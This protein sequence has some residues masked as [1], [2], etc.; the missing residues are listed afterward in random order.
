MA[1]RHV[2][3]LAISLLAAVAIGAYLRLQPRLRPNAQPKIQQLRVGM[4]VEEVEQVL[5]KAVW[6]R[7][8]PASATA[9]RE[10]REYKGDGAAKIFIRFDGGVA[11]SIEESKPR[12]RLPVG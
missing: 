12:N 10:L 8:L 5:G 3:F 7:P 4:T 9:K 2:V 6:I 11:E 1:R